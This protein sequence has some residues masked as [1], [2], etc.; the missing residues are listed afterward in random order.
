MLR[1]LRGSWCCF[2]IH[3]GCRGHRSVFAQ[4]CSAL[5]T[6]CPFCVGITT[7]RKSENECGHTTSIA[8]PLFEG[9]SGTG[10][11]G[12]PLVIVPQRQRPLL[13]G[14][15]PG[16]PSRSSRRSRHTRRLP[17]LPRLA[18]PLGELS[19]ARWA[20][21]STVCSLPRLPVCER[22]MSMGLV[23]R[24]STGPRGGSGRGVSQPVRGEGWISGRLFTFSGCHSRF[25]NLGSG[26]TDARRGEHPDP[27]PWTARQRLESRHGR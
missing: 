4:R 20:R 22:R 5:K 12:T 2:A 11:M 17:L 23:G 18:F 9:L 10:R 21:R 15:V 8:F 7:Q 13:G 24:L 16:H 3:A 6:V 25:P 19:L 26:V 1:G 27:E 14:A